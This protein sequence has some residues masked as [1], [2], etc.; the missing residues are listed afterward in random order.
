MGLAAKRHTGRKQQ[1][2]TVGKTPLLTGIV[3]VALALVEAVFVMSW[4]AAIEDAYLH[5]NCGLF[6]RPAICSQLS[7]AFSIEMILYAM[8]GVAL[9]LGII[10]SVRALQGRYA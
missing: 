7:A 5:S 2:G 8:L 9:L 1:Q 10:V 4:S 3:V 6:P